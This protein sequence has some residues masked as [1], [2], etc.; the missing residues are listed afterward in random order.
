VLGAIPETA[1]PL[2]LVLEDTLA[3][4]AVLTHDGV[5]AGLGCGGLPTAVMEGDALIGDLSD[6][7]AM[8]AD[9]SDVPVH[10][11]GGVSGG[12]VTTLGDRGV[13]ES[14]DL[15]HGW[16]RLVDVASIRGR[17]GFCGLSVPLRPLAYGADGSRSQSLRSRPKCDR[18]T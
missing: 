18:R 12:P 16:L 1:E 10:G 5:Q 8:K 13:H 9:L 4:E 6:Q 15:A 3:R 11:D 14:F 17:R 2:P 7:V